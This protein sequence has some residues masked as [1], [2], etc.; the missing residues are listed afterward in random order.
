MAYRSG[1]MA[2]TFLCENI[3]VIGP[4]FK[5]REEAVKKAR[6]Y[7]AGIDKTA[8]GRRETPVVIEIKRQDDGRYSIMVEGFQQPMGKLFNVDELFLK[9]FCKGLKKEM[10]I[11]TCF[12]EK[13]DELECLVLTEGLGA[14]LYAPYTINKWRP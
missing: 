9:R 12:V 5:D 14:V 10:F 3:P 13:V 2:L 7:L 8:A 4:R 1:D 11:L 6:Q